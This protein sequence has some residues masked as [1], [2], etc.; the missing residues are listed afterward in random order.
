MGIASDEQFRVL[1]A[2]RIKGFAKCD[3]LGELSGLPP[4]DVESHLADLQG[5]E[6]TLFR[7]ARA[8]W[9][10]TPKGREVHGVRL[11]GD[12]G[13]TGFQDVL[14]AN[15]DQ[16]LALNEGF[17]AL[18]G[19]WQLKDGAHNDH[20]DAKYDKGVIE[21]LLELD[22]E[23]RPVVLGMGD[24]VDRFSGYAP[25]LADTAKRVAKGESNLFTGV[26]CGSYH[27]I[28]MELHEDLILSLG[29]D[30]AKEGSF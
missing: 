5:E 9:Q 10:L 20:S 11:S 7:E 26:M 4:S 18:C 24:G 19:D 13:Q 1:H 29:I 2:L 23:A 17:K 25:R 8:L 12:V 21:R 15:Y 27:D 30:R 28:W 14:R 6:L 16:F 22:K 3:V